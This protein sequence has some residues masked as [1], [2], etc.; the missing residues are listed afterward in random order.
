MNLDKAFCLV[1]LLNTEE[2]KERMQVWFF[3]DDGTLAGHLASGT[4]AEMN[5]CLWETYGHDYV[6]ILAFAPNGKCAIKTVSINK[7]QLKFARQVIESTL[8]PL[9]ASD[10]Q[11][12]HFEFTITGTVAQVCAVDKVELEAITK[13]SAHTP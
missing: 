11:D 5:Q 10:I 7:G 3:H 12:T 6:P 13:P 8:E 2:H 4:L 9:L 1:H